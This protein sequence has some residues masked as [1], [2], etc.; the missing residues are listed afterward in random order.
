VGGEKGVSEVDGEE[1]CRED[2][3]GTGRKAGGAMRGIEGE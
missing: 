1:G 3:S 2:T